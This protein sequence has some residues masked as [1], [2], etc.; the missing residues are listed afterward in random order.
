MFAAW[1]GREGAWAW[2]RLEAWWLSR[3]RESFISGFSCFFVRQLMFLQLSL[4]FWQ[5][6]LGLAARAALRQPFWRFQLLFCAADDAFHF[7]P[8]F[9]AGSSG[10]GCLSEAETAFLAV[11]TAF[12]CGG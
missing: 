2:G 6:Q 1:L 12:L 3:R 4:P 11:S 7:E 8:A 5:A 10:V 9:L